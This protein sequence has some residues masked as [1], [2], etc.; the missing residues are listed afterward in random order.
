MEEIRTQTV[1]YRWES[2]KGKQACPQCAALHGQ[3]FYYHPQPGQTPAEGMPEPPLHPNCRCTRQPILDLVIDK[4]ILQSEHPTIKP[5]VE[6][7]VV[8]VV[9]LD[10]LFRLENISGGPIYGKN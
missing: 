8:R 2:S 5:Y 3:E 9:G 4:G 10:L 1:G 6:G 7:K